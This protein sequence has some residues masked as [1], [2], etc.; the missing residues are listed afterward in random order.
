MIREFIK[1]DLKNFEPNI[2][3]QYDDFIDIFDNY[4]YLKYSLIKEGKV[5]AILCFTN[6]WENNW[7]CFLL[8]CKG[9][10][11]CYAKDIKKFMQYCIK[12]LKPQKLETDSL[13]CPELNRWHKFLGFKLEGT[14]R[15]HIYGK[16]INMWGMLWE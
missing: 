8:M 14:K 12:K 1:E 7:N 2:Y 15:K 5:K 13:D 6:Y 3:S 11:F 16:D 10:E 9:F 4:E